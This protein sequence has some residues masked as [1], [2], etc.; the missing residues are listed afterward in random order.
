MEIIEEE[1]IS[2][3]LKTKVIELRDTFKIF[4][5]NCHCERN[6]SQIIKKKKPA[7]NMTLTYA[8]L[9]HHW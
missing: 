2:I 8:S 7:K 4:I 1:Q 9:E 5:S 6:Q 3:F